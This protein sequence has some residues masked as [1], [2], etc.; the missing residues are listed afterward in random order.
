MLDIYGI[1]THVNFEILHNNY[2]GYRAKLNSE[3]SYLC[4]ILTK[5]ALKQLTHFLLV[6]NLILFVGYAKGNR[7]MMKFDWT[8][9]IDFAK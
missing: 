6:A 4:K 8:E 7:E 2:H 9:V 1:N 3:G 5:R